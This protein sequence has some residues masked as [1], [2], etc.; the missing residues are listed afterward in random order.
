MVGT[1]ITF[2]CK[3]CANF[4]NEDGRDNQKIMTVKCSE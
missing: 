1:T 3:V 2:L 4:C